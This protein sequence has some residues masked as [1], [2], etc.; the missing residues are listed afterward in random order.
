MIAYL[1]DTLLEAEKNK[2]KAFSLI[3]VSQLIDIYDNKE[4]NKKNLFSLGNHFKSLIKYLIPT[5]NP[6]YFDLI[7]AIIA[8]FAPYLSH[9]K[10]L[11]TSI[12]EM[13]KA[14]LSI[15]FQKLKAENVK[16]KSKKTILFNKSLSLIQ[17]M[18][19]QEAFKPLLGEIEVHLIEVFEL[20]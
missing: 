8:N 11:V 7:T 9:H 14:K 10:N 3:I 12:V 16:N 17:F 13:V 18:V 1:I 15:L 20:F 4:Q 6:E 2:E 19:E 5:Q